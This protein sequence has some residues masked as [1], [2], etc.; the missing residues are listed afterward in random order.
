MVIS[1]TLFVMVTE[2]F[3]ETHWQTQIWWWQ[4]KTSTKLLSYVERILGL[5]TKAF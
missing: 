2:E 5:S 1:S 4:N 3:I